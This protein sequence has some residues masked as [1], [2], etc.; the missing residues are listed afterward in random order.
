MDNK[1]KNT[2]KEN[3]PWVMVLIGPPLSGKT[4]FINRDLK[5]FDFEVIS[6]DKIVIDVFGE[7]DYNSAF[8]NVDQKKVDKVLQNQFQSL[9]NSGKNVV[10]DMTNMTRKRRISNLSNFK[11]HY[12]IGVIFPILDLSEYESRN[13]KRTEEERKTIPMSVIKNMISSYQT[14][15]KIEGF[16][17]VFSLK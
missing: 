12:K 3:Q 8:A 11:S 9:S 14:I 10:I 13:K 1:M 6:R 5:E 4:T 15:S 7:D 17:K 16:D 2:L